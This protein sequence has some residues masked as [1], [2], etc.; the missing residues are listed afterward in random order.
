L[1]IYRFGIFSLGPFSSDPS[2]QPE[3]TERLLQGFATDR[4][5]AMTTPDNPF[6][7]ELK[8]HF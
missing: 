5:G 6:P 8:S 2:A 1:F 7:G 3:S 4:S